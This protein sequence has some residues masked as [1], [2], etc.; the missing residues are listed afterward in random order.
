MNSSRRSF[1][2]ARATRFY[3]ADFASMSETRRLGEGI[4]RDYDRL[5]VLVNNDVFYRS[6]DPARYTSNDGYEL[7]F[8]V[9]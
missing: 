7:H 4:L 8:H 3:Q 9:N 6:K 2:P 5:D 1:R